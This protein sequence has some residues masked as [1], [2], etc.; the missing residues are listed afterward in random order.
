MFR[1]LSE[2]ALLAKIFGGKGFWVYSLGSFK[3]TVLA[4]F[5]FGGH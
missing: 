4:G 5:R 1:V 2:H 3:S